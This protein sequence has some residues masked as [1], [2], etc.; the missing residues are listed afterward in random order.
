MDFFVCFNSKISPHGDIQGVAS[1][2]V[3]SLWEGTSFWKAI[4]PCLSFLEQSCF[5]YSPCDGD[6]KPSHVPETP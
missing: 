3:V 2:D 4:Q 6:Y 5:Q 1:D